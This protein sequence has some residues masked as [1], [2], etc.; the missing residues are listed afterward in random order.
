MKTKRNN[1][2]IDFE[3]PLNVDFPEV[4]KFIRKT[5]NVTQK[6]M[7][8]K[9]NTNLA[10]YQS[11]EYGIYVPSDMSAFK[12][13]LLYEYALSKTNQSA[14]TTELDKEVA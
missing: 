8:E 10:T 14:T 5:F 1:N 3:L 12:I 13:A 6:T 11:W 9:L 7:A 4:C 2:S